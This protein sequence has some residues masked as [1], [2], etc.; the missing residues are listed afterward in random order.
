MTIKVGDKVNYHSLI[1]GPVTSTGHEVTDIEEQPN[2]YGS[3]VAW[4][5]NKRGCVAVAA[6]SLYNPKPK[7]N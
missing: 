4:V 1:G 2:N 5:T 7:L 3:D 6:L